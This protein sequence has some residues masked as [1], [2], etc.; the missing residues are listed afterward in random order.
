MT[1]DDLSSADILRKIVTVLRF[2]A[3]FY[4]EEVAAT[5]KYA[6]GMRAAQANRH[7]VEGLSQEGGLL[8]WGF[9]PGTVFN[10]LT[11]LLPHGWDV[12]KRVQNLFFHECPMCAFNHKTEANRDRQWY[13]YN[14]Q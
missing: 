9:Y 14:R 6:E 4:P 11:A 5:K 12:N 2:W 10:L 8:A 3:K 7:G 13:G 1:C